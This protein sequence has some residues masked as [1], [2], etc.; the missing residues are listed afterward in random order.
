VC[1]MNSQSQNTGCRTDVSSKSSRLLAAFT[2]IELLVVIAIIAILAGLLLPALAR[3]KAQAKRIQCVNNQHQIGLCMQMYADDAADKMP[4]QDG[5]GAL[6]GQRPTNP[7]TSGN[8]FD[9]G[10]AE[11]E[12]NRPLNRYAQNVNVFHCPADKGDALNPDAGTCWDAWGNSYLLEWTVDLFGVK[13]VC[14]SGGKFSAATDPIKLSE[15]ALK[16]S[17]KLIQGDWPWQNNRALTANQTVWHNVRNQRSEAILF[18]D[19]HVEFYRFPT[20]IYTTV[21]RDKNPYW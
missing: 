10:G 14:G 8:A 15:I 4:V 13:Y 6:G 21:D 12:T 5:W 18:G 2:L 7:Y 3:A 16:P 17:T 1:N 9:Y 11:R 20:N 19:S